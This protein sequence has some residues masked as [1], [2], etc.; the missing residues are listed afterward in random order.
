MLIAH[1]SDPHVAGWGKKAYNIAPTAENLAR[2]VDHINRLNPQPELVLITGD[3]T[4]GGLPE[5]A[6]RAAAV[7]K[8]LRFPFYLVPGN[9]DNR[10]D[11]W[12][13]FGGGACPSKTGKFI[14]YVIEGYDIRLI[15]LDSTVPGAP[16]GKICKAR[17]DW[18]DARLAESEKRPTVIFLH[19]PPVRCGVLETDEDGFEG[20]NIFGDIIEKY[21]NIER[22]LCGHIHLEAHA[23]WRGTVVSAAPS[24]GMQLVL[25]LTMTQPSASVLEAPG[26]QLHYWTPE[27]NLV[28]HTIY[29]RKV[30]GPYLFE[31]YNTNTEETGT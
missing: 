16:G 28:S 22:V 24:T 1:I 23:A 14:N 13:V 9:H 21:V 26:Y 12:T 17:A 8:K 10:S 4:S 6:E 31:N 3:I 30:D 18:L 5:E 29:V 27:K 20:V 2:C 11:L 25:D 19:H 7:L 15:G